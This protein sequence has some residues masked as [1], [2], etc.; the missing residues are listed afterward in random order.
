LTDLFT[1]KGGSPIESE[2]KSIIVPMPFVLTGESKF[3]II[4]GDPEFPL[5][6]IEAVKKYLL[7]YHLKDDSDNP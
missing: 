3:K 7:A 5:I 1:G 2:G 4:Y 6:Y